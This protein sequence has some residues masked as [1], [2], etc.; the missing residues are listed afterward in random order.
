MSLKCCRLSST[1]PRINMFKMVTFVCCLSQQCGAGRN[2]IDLTIGEFF[3]GSAARKCTPAAS[4]ESV[5]D[6][7][8]RVSYV[9]Q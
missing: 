1:Y 6:R 9:C 2:F 4:V 5:I 8:F 3:V 7:P